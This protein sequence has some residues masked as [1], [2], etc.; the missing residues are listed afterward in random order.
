MRKRK[1]TR[2]GFLSEAGLSVAVSVLAPSC[3]SV[4]KRA[5]ARPN[6]VV[7]L[8]DDQAFR[9]IGYNNPA[10]KT[11]VLDALAAD[12]IIFENAYVASPIC[13]ASRSSLHTG[14]F[15]QQ[16][17]AIALTPVGFEQNVVQNK[18]YRTAAELLTEAGYD[19]ALY[20]KSHLGDPLRYG[21]R[22]GKE[23]NDAEAFEL[24][25]AFLQHAARAETPFFLWLAPHRPHLPLLP[26]QEWLDLYAHAELRLDPNFR[27]A[28]RDESFFN[29]GLPGQHFYR[30][31]DYTKNYKNLPGGPP[32]SADVI[33][34]FIRAYY[35][36]VSQLDH[37][38]GAT[39]AQLK[40][41]GRY[42]NTVL[43]FLSDNGYFLGNHGLGNK[44]TMHEE[45]V[46][47]PMFVHAPGRV[48]GG[49][50]CPELVSSLDLY[51]TLMELAGVDAP[52]CLMGRS[53]LPLFRNPARNFREYAASECVG[54]GGKKGEGH[55]MVRTN[56][57]KYILS[58]TN[59]EALFN[60]HADPFELDNRAADPSARP[61][62]TRLRGFMREWMDAVGDTHPRPPQSGNGISAS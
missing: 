53:L 38:L 20:G 39:V 36:S 5:S 15:P 22:Q 17:G 2:R 27:E 40:A 1:T 46:R 50:R 62:L 21:F 9:A 42:E 29:Q 13:V 60:E 52:R 19:T 61:V 45:S 48:R 44:I 55:R 33:L 4:P 35:A 57:W 23:T 14:V 37:E 6:I 16:H 49:A 28:P 24:A 12:G 34:E 51:P 7:V 8:T 3:A 43:V 11:P 41:S 54:A 59:D 25:K 31:C 56:E 30:D 32:R 18:V 10:V 58:D 47:V 26:E